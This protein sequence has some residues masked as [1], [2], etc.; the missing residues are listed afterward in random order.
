MYRNYRTSSTAK[1]SRTYIWQFVTGLGGLSGLI[2]VINAY[3][4]GVLL[5]VS[6]ATALVL[7]GIAIFIGYLVAG[8]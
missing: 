5:I 4:A 6:T 3:I 7:P 2:S 8:R 1:K